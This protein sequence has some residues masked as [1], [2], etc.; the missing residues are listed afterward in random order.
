MYI[1]LYTCIQCHVYIYIYIYFGSSG[2][3]VEPVEPCLLT[4]NSMTTLSRWSVRKSQQHAA[5]D[6]MRIAYEKC[7]Y[8]NTSLK[9]HVHVLEE[10]IRNYELSRNDKPN[11]CT[12]EKIP[13]APTEDKIAGEQIS[14][15]PSH[16]EIFHI[17]IQA[18]AFTAIVQMIDDYIDQL[19]HQ[20]P[21]ANQTDENN[22]KVTEFSELR[23]EAQVLLDTCPW[24][25]E[26]WRSSFSPWT[27]KAASPIRHHCPPAVTH[28]PSSTSAE[29]CQQSSSLP[30]D[31]ER[32]NRL[33]GPSRKKHRKR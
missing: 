11:M 18:P 9:D 27:E 14:S 7:K 6:A 15:D 4:T 2:S 29:P 24:S 16:N 8:E 1:D 10:Q 28:T 23:E 3:H 5:R 19:S 33:S 32:T 21:T 20:L 13:F 17:G 22:L 26:S 31:I 12:H 30:R 25:V